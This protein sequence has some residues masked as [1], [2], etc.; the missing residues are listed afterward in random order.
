MVVDGTDTGKNEVLLGVEDGK[1]VGGIGSDGIRAKLA[2][3]FKGSVRLGPASGPVLGTWPWLKKKGPG[4]VVD[5]RACPHS[6]FFFF[7]FKTFVL[8]L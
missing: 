6:N 7:R 3:R 1:L 8:L 2:R 4:T 5:R